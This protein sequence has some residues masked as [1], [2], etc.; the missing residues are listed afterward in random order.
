MGMWLNFGEMKL[1]MYAVELIS[2][3]DN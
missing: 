1:I 2:F 3:G